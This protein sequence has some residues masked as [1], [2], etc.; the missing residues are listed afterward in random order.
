MIEYGTPQTGGRVWEGVA[1][2]HGG[3][4]LEI[5]VLKTRFWVRYKFRI[6]IKSSSKCIMIAVQGVSGEPF[7]LNNVYWSQWGGCGRG[8]PLPRW[9]FFLNFGYYIQVF[10]CIIKFEL[11]LAPKSLQMFMISV[12]G[13]GETVSVVIKVGHQGEGQWEARGTLPQ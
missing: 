7:L 3:E 12:Q 10:L 1:P 4:F 6:N 13:V 11:T 2:S 9:G 8:Y 5:W